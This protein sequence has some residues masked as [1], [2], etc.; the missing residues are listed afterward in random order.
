MLRLLDEYLNAHFDPSKK[1][2]INQPCKLTVGYAEGKFKKEGFIGDEEL[3]PFAAY[4]G[5]TD[6]LIIKFSNWRDPANKVWVEM[7]YYDACG[8]LDDFQ[9]YMANL[10]KGHESEADERDASAV[11]AEMKQLDELVRVEADP[12]FGS[13]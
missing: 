1:F 5:K 12:L 10:I 3:A 9:F 13:W 4:Y 11:L 8:K 6:K 7:D 2:L